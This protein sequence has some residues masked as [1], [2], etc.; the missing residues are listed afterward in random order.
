MVAELEKAEK[1]IFLEFFTIK[2]GKMWNTIF[3]LL[4]RKAAQGLDI[5]VIYDDMGN[6]KT[7]PA[8]YSK[9]LEWMGVKCAVFNPMIPVLTV[10]HNNRNHR[11]VIIIDGYT[12]ITG[13]FNLADE[14][15]N[16]VEKYGYW[17]DSG[18]IIQGKA[19]MNLLVPYIALWNFLRKAGDKAIDF[20]PDSDEIDVE[21]YVLPYTV[22]PYLEEDPA[23]NIYINMIARA[24]RYVYINTPYFI[25][26]YAMEHALMA[27]AMSGVDVRIC[28][29]GIYDKF[30]THILSRS[31]FAPLV[32]AGVQFYT[33]PVGFMHSKTFVCDDELAI[34]GT[35]NLDYRSLFLHF[36]NAVWM[37][38]TK[39]V[40]QVKDDFLAR[41]KICH[42]VT[43]EELQNTHWIKKLL[44]AI[45]KPFAPFY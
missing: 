39:A 33:Y 22:D 11:K 25:I 28:F 7:L 40:Q 15:I 29:P 35:I 36:E 44:C 5:R 24:K 6:M 31:Y 21:G 8:G 2:E 18:I 43:P 14:Y 12:G 37:Y 38:K 30:F 9:K 17:V 26:D 23:N 13:G 3:E 20:L 42:L 32:E 10:R 41:Q 1:Y 34:V 19:V 16:A 45:M 27:A 4:Q